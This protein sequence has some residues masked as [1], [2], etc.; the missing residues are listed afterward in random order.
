[1]EEDVAKVGEGEA[2]HEGG[3]ADAK[4]HLQQNKNW[5][6]ML[7]GKVELIVMSKT[8]KLCLCESLKCVKF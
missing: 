4:R 5:F 2:E 3:D 1:M 6:K 8:R 7:F